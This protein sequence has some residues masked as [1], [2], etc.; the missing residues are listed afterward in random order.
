MKNKIIATASFGPVY[1]RKIHVSRK[2]ES[3]SGLVWVYVWSTNSSR[4]CADAIKSA[5]LRFPLEQFTAN[6]AKD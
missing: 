5:L 3:P 4:T 1:E 2:S 6:F